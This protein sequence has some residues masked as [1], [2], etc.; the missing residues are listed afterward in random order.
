[1]YVNDFD[2]L[3]PREGG[4]LMADRGYYTDWYREALQDKG[5]KP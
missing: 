2:P 5:I 3:S 1:M 4:R